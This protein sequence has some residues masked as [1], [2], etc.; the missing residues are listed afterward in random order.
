[1][2]PINNRKS[3]KMNIN[4]RDISLLQPP[5]YIAEISGNHN[6]SK[7]KAIKLIDAAKQSGADAVK[8]QCYTA[9]SITLNLDT[10]GFVL[11]RGPWK[12]RKLWDLYNEAHTP[13]D[14]FPDLFRH[15]KEIGITIFSS[16]FDKDAVDFLQILDCPAYKIS[17]FDIVDLEL[18]KYVTKTGKP[19]IVSMGMANP[20]E[21]S[22]A[23][24]C[25]P[26]EYQN[27]FL[28]CVSGYPTPWEESDLCEFL[29]R[30]NI[31]GDDIGISDHSMG[32]AV[33]C[34]VTAIGAIAIEKHLT[35]S[36]ADG[37]PDSAFS[38]EPHEFKE[39][40]E[41]CR[42][43]WS[44]LSPR[45]S[46]KSENPQKSL[47][48]S[49]YIVSEVRAGEILQAHHVRAI[50]PGYGLAPRF[51]NAVLGRRARRNLPIGSPVVWD[52]LTD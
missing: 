7:E 29:V 42:G 43:I 33:P 52:D 15:A 5:Y 3:I 4:G 32:I 23:A 25:I 41:A 37:G 47:R 18:I 51:Y 40:T 44:A 36:R 11:V 39:M 22:E 16:V 21:I 20:Q 45:P 2:I 10:P 27:L 38:M 31:V 8:L 46:P 1:M 34:A 50:R 30:R 14:W 9:D 24:D 28:H 12:G 49:L 48:K 6:G 13:R 35:L 19:I 26:D 17:S